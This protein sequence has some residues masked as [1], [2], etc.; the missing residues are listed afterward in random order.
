MTT[1]TIS[2]SF[3]RIPLSESEQ[4]SGC[5]FSA[6][7]IAN[8]QNMRV[9]IAEQKLN[10]TFTPNDVLSYA[11]QEAFLKGQLEVL[12]HLIDLSETTQRS[13]NPPKST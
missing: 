4:V 9:D 5:I 3:Q 2:S 7:Q 10:L 11:Q 12:Q 1:T 13:I 6:H 8:L